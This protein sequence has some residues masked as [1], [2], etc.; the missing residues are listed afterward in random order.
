MHQSDVFGR[1]R[2]EYGLLLRFIEAGV[3]PLDLVGFNGFEAFRLS[4][5]RLTTVLS[6]PYE[7]GDRAARAMLRRLETGSFDTAESV[8]PVAFAANLTT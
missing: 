3:K 6:V 5:P 7:M 4:T 2:L 8:L 1:K